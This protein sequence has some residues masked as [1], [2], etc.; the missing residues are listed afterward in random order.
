MRNLLKRFS[1]PGGSK[2]IKDKKN[3]RSRVAV[4]PIVSPETGDV[5]AL[6]TPLKT[7]LEGLPIEIQS[8]VLLSIRDIASLKSLIHASPKYHSAYLSQRHAILQRVLF[9]SIHPDALYDAFSAITS[10]KTLTSS[11]EDQVARVKAFLSEYKDN[12]DTWTPSEHLDL[13]SAYRLAQLQSQV[14][15]A[16]E[17][18]CQ[19]AFSSHPSSGNPVEHWEQLS[20]NE[21][22]RF[23]RAFSSLR[24]LL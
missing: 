12:R 24:D 11:V 18:F 16:T 22:R 5:R 3:D 14:Q 13:E 1:T 17:D 4:I 8:A 9:N 19:Q 7:S 2:T 6:N 10:S 23:H 15:H 21:S 20:S